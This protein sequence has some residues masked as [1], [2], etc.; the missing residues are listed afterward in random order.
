MLVGCSRDLS[1]SSQGVQFRENAAGTVEDLFLT[2]PIKLLDRFQKG[3]V[4]SQEERCSIWV[5]WIEGRFS[6]SSKR[7]SSGVVHKLPADLRRALISDPPALATWED[8]T[9]LARN[10]WICWIGGGKGV[11]L[12]LV[13]CFPASHALSSHLN[14]IVPHVE[15]GRQLGKRQIAKFRPPLSPGIAACGR[16]SSAVCETT[17][18]SD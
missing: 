3:F 12:K 4:Q 8:I 1:S 11:G 13:N 16:W 10:E 6:M 18:T 5:W 15:G 9:P 14:S 7:I 2:G 17:G